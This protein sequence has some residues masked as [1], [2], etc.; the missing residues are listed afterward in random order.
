[1]LIG[2]SLA[3]GG[4]STPMS[5]DVDDVQYVVTAAG[6]YGSFDTKTGDYVIAY[7]LVH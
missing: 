3:A 7:A 1:M 2:L 4:Q 6:G 5:Y